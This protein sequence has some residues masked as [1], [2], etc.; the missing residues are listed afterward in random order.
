MFP[1][2]TRKIG[3]TV[4]KLKNEIDNLEK[5]LTERK[6]QINAEEAKKITEI[7]KQNDGKFSE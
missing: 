5:Y 2:Q 4:S 3:Y 1:F 7:T 6:K